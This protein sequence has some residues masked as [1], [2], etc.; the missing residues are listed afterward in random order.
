MLAKRWGRVNAG[1]RR[2]VAGMSACA[3]IYTEGGEPAAGMSLGS[4]PYLY[5]PRERLPRE[6]GLCYT[7]ALFGPLAQLVE[8]LTL[9]QLVAGSSPA[10]LTSI[11]E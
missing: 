4:L 7:P 2:M 3:M 9:N 10:R 1:G 8:Q 6:R 5:R 11:E